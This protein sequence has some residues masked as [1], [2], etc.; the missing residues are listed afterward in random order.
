MNQ[1]TR[2]RIVGTVVLLALALIFLP[3]IFDGEGSYQRPV[4]SRIP[5][6]PIVSL[7]PEPVAQ[8]VVIEA[9]EP[10][11]REP[12]LDVR[13]DPVANQH[14]ADSTPAATP[15]TVVAIAAPVVAPPDSSENGPALDEEGLPVGWSVRLGSFADGRNAE[16]LLQRLLAAR[17][18]AYS[19]EIRTDQGVMTA[20]YVGPQLE[21]DKMEALRQELQKEFNLSGMVVRFEIEAL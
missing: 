9:P 1:S 11:S 8:R 7:L 16:A 21:R 12:A 5:D 10:N 17:Y 15:E 6:P 13:A 4:T 14:A 20:V 19:R 18:K 2:Q 3:M